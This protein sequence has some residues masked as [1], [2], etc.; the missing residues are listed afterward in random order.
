M[1]FALDFRFLTAIECWTRFH[2]EAFIKDL[3]LEC[4]RSENNFESNTVEFGLFVT[5]ANPNPWFFCKTVTFFSFP[6]FPM[7]LKEYF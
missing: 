1:D 6:I 7:Y 4:A 5:S 2:S 3:E